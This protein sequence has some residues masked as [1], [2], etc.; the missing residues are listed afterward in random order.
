MTHTS[1]LH[2]L[3]ALAAFLV[4][5]F[6]TAG[7]GAVASVSAKDFYGQLVQP[8][9]APPGWLFGPVWTTLFILMAVAAW[10][11]WRRRADTQVRLALTVYGVQLA[12]NALWTWLFFAWQQG[13]WALVEIAL[14]WSLIAITINRFWAIH[15]VAAL[16]LLP[17]LAWVSFAAALNFSLL[18]LNPLAL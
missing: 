6:V 16:L 9:W 15:R 12:F 13:D 11:I 3:L 17:Y 10:L 14:L 8:S 4:L 5:S 1:R 2:D 7:V 18:Q